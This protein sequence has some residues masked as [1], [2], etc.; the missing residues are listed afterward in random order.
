MFSISVPLRRIPSAI[1][2]GARRVP[3]RG[4]CRE[5]L[6][7]A[8]AF[9]PLVHRFSGVKPVSGRSAAAVGSHLRHV[10][11]LDSDARL[12][13]GQQG[14]QR[15]GEA[16]YREQGERDGA[17]EHSQSQGPIPEYSAAFRSMSIHFS[18]STWFRFYR[19]RLD[20]RCGPNQTLI[21]L[22]SQWKHVVR[23]VSLGG[24]FLILPTLWS[25]RREASAVFLIDAIGVK[26]VQP[27]GV[28]PR[29]ALEDPPHLGG[30]R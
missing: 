27:P 16:E 17:S 23:K 14:S 25:D 24:G 12:R 29:D 11:R 3:S 8:A 10:L 13:E 30:H 2:P 19:F 5:A 15:H 26:P 6:Q 7:V 20:I 1:R 9:L 22:Q 21:Y 28:V 18:P 4:G